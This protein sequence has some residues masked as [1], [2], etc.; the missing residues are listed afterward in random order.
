[1]KRGAMDYIVKSPEVFALIPRTLERTLQSW[2]LLQ[3]RLR[4]EDALRTALG[5]Y[6]ALFE[7]FPM[8]I[9]VMDGEGGFWRVTRLL[10]ILWGCHKEAFRMVGL[11]GR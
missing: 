1:M 9:T 6:K 8:G 2:R 7:A 4:A 10:S 11:V 5:K 3:E